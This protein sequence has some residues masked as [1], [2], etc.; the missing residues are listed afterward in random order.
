[1]SLKLCTKKTVAAAATALTT[2][3]AP[4]AVLGLALSQPGCFVFGSPGPSMVGQGKKYESGEPQFDQFFA[5]LYD[6][7]LE[8]AK[9]PGREKELRQE[10]AKVTKSDPDASATLLAKKIEKRT[11]ELAEAGT[12]LKLEVEGLE[13][14]GAPSVSLKTLGKDLSGDDKALVDSVEKTAKGEAQLLGRMREVTRELE[15]MRALSVALD[16]Q[17]DNAFRKGGPSKKAEVRKNLED[18]RTLMPLMGARAQETEDAAKA[19]LKKLQEAVSTEDSYKK[20]E[21]P[22]PPPPEE[23][24]AESAEG[25]PKPKPGGGKPAGGKPGGSSGG[26]SPPPPPPPQPPPDFEP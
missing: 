20:E 23:E 10:L 14:S 17:V 2:T 11:K 7:Q 26:T 12:G 25:K 24:P 15:Q 22:P 3:F 1:M 6:L 13:G 21:P 8:M 18:A 19:T 5:Q 9:A 16:Q 4:A